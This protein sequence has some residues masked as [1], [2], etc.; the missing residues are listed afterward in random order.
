MPDEIRDALKEA[1]VL[2]DYDN[3]P[4]YQRNDYIGWIGKSK[5]EETRRKRIEQMIAELKQGGVYMGMKHAPSSK[6]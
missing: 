4:D 5:Q 3:R 6:G 2:S 1:G